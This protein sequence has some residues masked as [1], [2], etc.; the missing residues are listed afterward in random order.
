MNAWIAVGASALL[1]A[2]FARQLPA[3]V[4]SESCDT[5]SVQAMAP[6]D[7]TIAAAVR[8]GGG[9][10]RV[11]GHVTTRNPGPNQVLFV[12]GLPDKFNGRYVYLGVGGA[13]AN[14]PALPPA[15]LA[16]G[17]VLAGSNAGTGSTNTYDFSFKSDPAKYTDFLW[18]GVRTSATV[19]QQI[20]KAYYKR[21]DIHRYISGC[22]GGGQMGLGNALRFGGENF[23]GFI[24]GATVWPGDP[25]QPNVF[26]IAQH[27]Q[28][29]PE[30]W[31]SPELL[32]RADAA[33][34]AAYD[35]T[36]GAVDGIIHD[37]RDI[38]SF[39]L[40][41]L[42]KAGFTP[43]QIG[44]FNLIT[45]S[46]KFSGHP[47]IHGDGVIPGFPPTQLAN[48]SVFLL[49]TKP[50]PWP[51]SSDHSASE[52]AALGAASIHTM[53]DTNT[54]AKYPGRDYVSIDDPAELTRVAMSTGEVP[55]DPKDF[56]KLD[57]SGA[58]MLFW[59]GVNDD[60][61]SYFETLKGY[62][63]LRARFPGSANWLRAFTV[64]GLW[65]CRGGSG[66]TD[67]DETMIESMANWVEKG[68]AP[69]SAV[70]SRYSQA[71]GLERSFKLCAEPQRARLIKSG[72]DPLQAENWVCKLPAASASVP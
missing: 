62:E 8:D 39:D 34:L 6:P 33:I 61:M 50:P 43:A 32:Q 15:L 52:L 7:T 42:R 16:K 29:H 30:S 19:T 70:A 28:K 9:L 4:P 27:V 58:K 63:E 53:T 66:P 65:H 45:Q 69:E 46:R 5:E 40:G 10:C 71:K 22:S 25:Y 64:P 31:L 49:G 47:N 12:L 36:D 3:A 54:R 18:R 72:L 41:I 60:S 38:T 59:H 21:S 11:Y 13:A 37:A 2:A 51:N 1:A 17:Y 68:V 44:T 23:D 67:I 26:T 57:Q 56:S 55:E 35:G 20:V 48:W 24:I 14:L